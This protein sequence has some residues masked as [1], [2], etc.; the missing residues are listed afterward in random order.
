MKREVALALDAE[1]LDML[2]YE[3][4]E[5]REA[6]ALIEQERRAFE[7]HYETN[8]EHRNEMEAHETLYGSFSELMELH[9]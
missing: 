8:Y 7:A 4:M 2:A 6:G 1:Y 9:A 5:A 3:E